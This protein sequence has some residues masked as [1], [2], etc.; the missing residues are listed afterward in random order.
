MV[1][2]T[3]LESHTLG[4]FLDLALYHLFALFSLFGIAYLNL[5]TLVSAD[6]RDKRNFKAADYRVHLL[7]S[8]IDHLLHVFRYLW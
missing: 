3:S 2:R 7:V 5:S 8:V 6:T 4:C 1:P